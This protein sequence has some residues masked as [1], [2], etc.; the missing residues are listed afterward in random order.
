MACSDGFLYDSGVGRK[1]GFQMQLSPYESLVQALASNDVG[2]L[3]RARKKC[4]AILQNNPDNAAFLHLMG[5]IEFQLGHIDLASKWI[6]KVLSVRPDSAELHYILAEMLAAQKKYAEAIVS[7]K[8]ALVLKPDYAKAYYGL[9]LVFER[10][11][12]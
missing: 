3:K 7:F 8:R 9:G 1:E 12:R 10:V 4:G 5:S 6:K 2:Q 11:R